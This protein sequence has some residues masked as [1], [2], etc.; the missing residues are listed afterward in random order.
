MSLDMDQNI[1]GFLIVNSKGLILEK[2][3][4]QYVVTLLLVV[5]VVPRLVG[6]QQK[7]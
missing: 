6:K 7:K 4:T 3:V 2:T 1:W 5:V